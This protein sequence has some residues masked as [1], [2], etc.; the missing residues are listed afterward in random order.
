MKINPRHWRWL[1]ESE[2]FSG[3]GYDYGIAR[4]VTGMLIGLFVFLVVGPVSDALFLSFPAALGL[5]AVCSTVGAFYWWP[6]SYISALRKVNDTYLRDLAYAY[7]SMPKQYRSEFP[8]DFIK[9]I[10]AIDNADFD[11]RREF[12]RIGNDMMSE[13]NKQHQMLA[14]ASE[15]KIDM[16]D[17]IE[18]L[19]RR[20]DAVVITTQTYREYL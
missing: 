12:A 20:K 18:E 14:V 3:E 4:A 5:A 11:Q 1:R 2:V 10:K 7:W 17:A 6:M 13:L 9:Q 15:Q 16:T 19:K 8:Q